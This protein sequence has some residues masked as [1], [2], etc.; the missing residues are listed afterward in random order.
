M[1]R[2]NRAII[3]LSFFSLMVPFFY[4]SCQRT[5]NG[6][7]D[8]SSTTMQN[9]VAGNPMVADKIAASICKVAKRCKPQTVEQICVSDVMKASGFGATMNLSG[10]DTLQSIKQGER[11]ADLK[12]NGAYTELCL[13]KIESMS[14]A[15]PSAQSAVSAPTLLLS[16]ETC[17]LAITPTLT[18]SCSAKTFVKGNVGTLASTPIVGAGTYSISPNLPAGLTLDPSTGV[19]SGSATTVTPL[20]TY[21]IKASYAST[22]RTSSVQIQTADGFAVNDLGDAGNTGG[23]TCRTASGTC[24]LRAAIDAA[25]RAGGLIVLP[26][27]TIKVTTPL[28]ITKGMEIQGD[29]TNGT[30]IDGMGK[31]KILSITAGPTTLDHLTI[32]NG[33][34]TGD[35]GAGIGISADTV[36]FTTT[37]RRL[38]VRNNQV[39]NG[40]YGLSDGAGIFVFA[41]GPS[42]KATVILSDST[43]SNNINNNGWYGAGMGLWSDTHVEITNCTFSGNQN[44]TNYGG[45]LSSR[46]GSM[47]ISQTLFANN[48]SSG[49]GGGIFIQHQAPQKA[50]LTN[51]TFSNNQA[52]DGGAVYIGGNGGMAIKNATFV[53]NRST[54]QNYG[55]ALTPQLV[56]IT[57]ENSIFSGNTAA[58]NARS[59]TNENLIT[60]LGHN[61]SDTGV[62]DCRFNASEDKNGQ[63]LLLGPLQGNG[64]STQTFAILPGSPAI[65]NASNCPSVDQRGL[66]RSTARCDSGA[67]ENLAEAGE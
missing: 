16:Q 57:V 12:P 20:T 54:S 51:V 49:E 36:P 7:S 32:Q 48:T 9:T 5:S 4:N 26:A 24:T 45:A 56:N 1:K 15:D 23:S 40:A 39:V 42:S 29:C 10:F 46:S 22:T 11:S 38:V 43:V 19:I 44:L 27:G 14:C 35:S 2:S 58:G 18:Y 6:S 13:N 8:T 62:S 52:Q 65:D 28:S 3:I 59:C 61:V 53:G 64:G 31:T 60:S 67:F 33:H 55:G 66:P 63:A 17:G 34:S 41:A 25:N 30:V 37:L 50:Y 47:N 21:T